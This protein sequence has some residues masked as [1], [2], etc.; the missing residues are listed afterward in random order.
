MRKSLCL[1][2][3]AF[4]IQSCNLAD[5]IPTPVPTATRTPSPTL[6]RTPT[7]TPTST[8]TITLTPRD[9]ATPLDIFLTYTPFSLV[10]SSLPEYSLSQTPL[11]PTGGFDT[12][13][14]S[15]GKIY[16]GTCKQGY[17]KMTIRVKHAEDVY[18]VY[19]FFRLETAKPSGK[20]TP[21]WG[22]VTDNDGG[23]YFIYTLRAN[24]IPE[25]KNFIKAWVQ[26]QF[27]AVNAELEI[28]GR[29]QIYSRNL[30]LEP[31]K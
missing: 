19:L 5:F 30:L 25:R 1:F 8:P 14:L 3:V 27:V 24:N 28:I 31:C 9:T 22:T 12:I 16:Y 17:T 13:H 4:L 21:W 10:D 23:G 7:K 20:T 26:Y 6:T 18:R 11:A 2:L 15:Q 29:T